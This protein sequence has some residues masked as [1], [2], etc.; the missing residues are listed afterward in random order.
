V[1]DLSYLR[2]DFA[3][4]GLFDNSANALHGLPFLREQMDTYTFQSD[5]FL[6]HEGRLTVTWGQARWFLTS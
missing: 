2:G 1:R 5:D 3:R 6:R 4:L